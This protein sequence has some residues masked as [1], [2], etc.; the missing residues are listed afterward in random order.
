M[1][2]IAMAAAAIGCGL[3]GACLY[4]ALLLA[5]PGALILVYLTQLP[6]FIAGLWLGTAMDT[7][8]TPL[9]LTASA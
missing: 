7:G 6:L 1:T 9:G 3:A 5:S 2:R 8:A 4:L